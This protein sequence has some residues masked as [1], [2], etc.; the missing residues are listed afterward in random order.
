MRYHHAGLLGV[1]ASSFATCV[2][3][4]MPR[5]QKSYLVAALFLLTIGWAPAQVTEVREPG[6]E[7]APQQRQSNSSENDSLIQSVLDSSHA[8]AAQLSPKDGVELLVRLAD[9]AGKKNPEVARQWDLEAFH[10]AS[11][12]PS[13]LQRAHYEVASITGLASV[14]SREALAL[15]LTLEFP[16]AWNDCEARATATGAVFRQFL[17]Q[18]PNDWKRLT[19][20]A[21]RLGERGNYPFHAVQILIR[22]IKNKAPETATALVQHAIQ[23]YSLGAHDSCSNNKLAAL[24]AEDSKLVSGSALKAAVETI[25]SSLWNGERGPSR[26]GSD[27]GSSEHQVNQSTL[28]ILLPLI[29]AFDPQM[30]QKLRQEQPP[31]L[32]TASVT[33][34][35]A[36]RNMVKFAG[37]PGEMHVNIVFSNSRNQG[38]LQE[39]ASAPKV[40]TDGAMS[41]LQPPSP[42]DLAGFLEGSEEASGNGQNPEQQLEVL[43]ERGLSLVSAD[44]QAELSNALTDA[45]AVGEKLFRKSVNDDP[46]ASWKDR[47]GAG[48]LSILVESAAKSAPRLVLEKIRNTHNSVLQAQLYVCF[49]AAMQ[50]EQDSASAVIKVE[51]QSEL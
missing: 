48:A 12:M 28:S 47:P 10:I 21:Q 36:D 25:L 39:P 40:N 23:Y 34:P 8:I 2:A 44:R 6:R 16:P 49:V 20:V 50:S 30:A 15:L 42:E 7:A 26:S 9:M 14:D 4:Q 19:T 17:R 41:V 33:D 1:I 5:M 32:T 37:S 38:P 46:Q 13:G 11:D 45:F 43:L 29:N 3:Q 31:A 22:Q 18:H 51:K 35:E 24:L 27:S